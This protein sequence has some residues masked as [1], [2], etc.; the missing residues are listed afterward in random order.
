MDE[1][2]F[3]KA[4]PIVDITCPGVGIA[5]MTKESPSIASIIRIPFF[6]NTPH[7]YNGRLARYVAS[8]VSWIQ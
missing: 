8:L 4:T 2:L 3:D 7:S 5:R 6:F 1:K